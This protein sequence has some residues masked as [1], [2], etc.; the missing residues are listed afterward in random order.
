MSNQLA[1]R[2]ITPSVWQTI[3]AV[4][5]AMFKSRLFGVASI[6]Q[7][8]AIM[9]KGFELGLGLAAS[10]EFIN[11]IQGK[12]ALS[13][14]GALALIHCSGELE[15]MKVEDKPG[16]CTV[17]MRRKNGFEYTLTFTIEE[18]RAAGLVKSGGAWESWQP[19]M[20]RWRA[21]GFVADVVFPDLLGGLKRAD[22]Y[23]AAING[24]GDVIEGEWQ[25]ATPGV[26]LDDLVAQY[27]PERIMEAADGKIPATIE[28]I[29]MVQ[30]ALEQ[31]AAAA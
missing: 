1:V 28:E 19:N 10:F 23:G 16:A 7:A 30:Q 13:P 26:S 18:A 8:Q 20:L 9:T 24:Q 12:P 25:T 17:M 6:E 2:D 29:M 3:E 21:I 22:E 11:I 15:G 5:P 4:A 27:G 14:R 31:E